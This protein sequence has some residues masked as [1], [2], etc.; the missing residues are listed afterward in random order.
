MAAY[1][2]KF[3][4][5]TYDPSKGTTINYK[6]KTVKYDKETKK[7][8]KNKVGGKNYGISLILI[9]YL[10]VGC[11]NRQVKPPEKVSGIPEKAI[12]YGGADGGC[13]ILI[14]STPIRNQYNAE[15]Y[16]DSSGEL[17]D[18]GVYEID[19]LITKR[20]FTVKE[21]TDS[22]SGYFGS[23]FISTSIV[24]NGKWVSLTRVQIQKNK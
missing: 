20:T 6:D 17:W 2:Y 16:F 7:Q 22:I 1:Q 8:L 15:C 24:R 11:F 19:T 21:L 14:D 18:K 13:W 5:L 4:P 10:L 3:T 23:D 12:W 9:V